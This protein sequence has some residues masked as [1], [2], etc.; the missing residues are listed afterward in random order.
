MKRLSLIALSGLVVMALAGA[1]SEAE[2]ADQPASGPTF[3]GEVAPILN[4][5]CVKCHQEGS[6]GPFALDTFAAVRS[7][8]DKIADVTRDGVMPPYLIRHDGSC[9]DFEDDEALTSTELA[10]IQAWASGARSEGTPAQLSRPPRH[11]LEEG[12]DSKDWKTPELMPVAQGGKLAE[13]DEYRCYA[14]D[15]GLSRDV[16]IT[17][18]E[19]IPGNGAIVHHVLGFLVDPDKA[20]ADGKTNST[21]MQALDDSDPDRPGWPC[22]GAAGEGVTVDSLPVNWAPG[23]GPLI[24]PAG[25]GIK[26]GKRDKLVVQVHYNLAHAGHRGQ[27]DSTTVRVRFADTVTQ[28]LVFVL[29]DGLL[30]TAFGK[31]PTVLA[32]GQKATAYTWRMTGAELGFGQVQPEL[33]AVAPHMHE[34][35]VNLELRVGAADTPKVCAARIDR[36]NFHWQRLYFYKGPPRVLTAASEIEVT[37]T[38]DTSKDTAPV[39][40]G[41]GTRNEMCLPLLMLKLPPGL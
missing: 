24:Y 39:L 26:V 14:L 41:W 36:W 32:P 29:R 38:Y 37:C 9:G 8:A 3:W 18:N 17:A 19:V 7:R 12:P 40:P 27:S 6:V 11:R 23:I 35:G 16:F 34:R 4:T 5:K 15:L 22:F 10:T 13:F 33:I 2:H 1:C 28:R 31:T 20:G 30:E 21:L 25:T